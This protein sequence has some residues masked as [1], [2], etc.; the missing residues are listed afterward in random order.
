MKSR[1]VVVV[2]RFRAQIKSVHLWMGSI[3]TDLTQVIATS[4]VTSWHSAPDLT[5][6]NACLGTCKSVTPVLGCGFQSDVTSWC[7]RKMS[8]QKRFASSLK[9]HHRVGCLTAWCDG[10]EMCRGFPVLLCREVV[11]LFGGIENV[12]ASMVTTVMMMN[13]ELWGHRG[14]MGS[15]SSWNFRRSLYPLSGYMSASQHLILNMQ[16]YAMWPLNVNNKKQSFKLLQHGAAPPVSSRE[17]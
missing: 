4:R 9:L 7:Q 13:S 12:T 15:T 16:E 11:L 8:L 17:S 6:G 3:A 14:L 1:V 5:N 10:E 2:Y